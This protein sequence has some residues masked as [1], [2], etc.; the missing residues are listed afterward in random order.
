MNLKQQ[1]IVAA[2]HSKSDLESHMVREYPE[3]A[4]FWGSFL[5]LSSKKA[6]A[7]NYATHVGNYLDW[8][9]YSRHE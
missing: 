1:A 7:E 9:I 2:H 3:L 8:L 6:L 4:G 5:Y